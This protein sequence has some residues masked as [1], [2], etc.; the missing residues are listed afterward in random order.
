[1]V[2]DVLMDE[3][4][5]SRRS[6]RMRSRCGRTRL[7]VV[8][9]AVLMM[10]CGCAHL[11]LQKN[12]VRQANTVGDIYEQQVLDNLARFV[13]NPYATPSFSVANQA[14][15][16]ITDHGE[17]GLAEGAFSARFWA[18]LTAGGSRDQSHDFTMNP[19]TNPGRLR[20]MQCAYQAAIG[21]PRDECDDCCKLMDE[22]SGSQHSCADPCGITCGWVCTSTKWRDV[23]KCCCNRY[24]EYCG[25][26]VWVAPCH[27]R[28]F[29][30]LVAAVLD[31]AAGDPKAS[32]AETK[33]IE[34]YLTKDGCVST[35]KE[36]SQKVTV[37]APIQASESEIA[38]EL[39]MKR[40][41]ACT[42]RKISKLDGAIRNAVG[43]DAT[44]SLLAKK[45]DLENDLK[46]QK[47]AL[48]RVRQDNAVNMPRTNFGPATQFNSSLYG[49]GILQFQQ[50]LNT[51]QRP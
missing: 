22:W 2:V 38:Q 43:E 14:T 21:L 6:R 27:H 5:E 42:Q 23:P 44:K 36:Y 4:G 40:D 34:I 25:T 46:T 51:I 8:V 26:Y 16:G 10:T 41:I 47:A 13:V 1:M 39:S 48:D 19:V 31:Y 37:V 7:H 9:G 29:S 17:V 11:Q 15:N 35:N 28:E 50:R 45:E 24:G 32:F 18:H 30:K 33:L 12:T 20:L 3:C 49:G